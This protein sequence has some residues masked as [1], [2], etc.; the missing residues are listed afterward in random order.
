MYDAPSIMPMASMIM[1]STK[2]YVGLKSWMPTTA[3]KMPTAIPRRDASFNMSITN[4]FVIILKMLSLPMAL[5]VFPYFSLGVHAPSRE[6]FDFAARPFLEYVICHFASF[7]LQRPWD[8]VY[9]RGICIA[10]LQ[11]RSPFRTVCSTSALTGR[12]NITSQSRF[13]KPALQ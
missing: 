7:S 8:L 10:N 11:M 6:N 5:N 3:M 12:S 1:M 9:S 13:S 2:L 4:H